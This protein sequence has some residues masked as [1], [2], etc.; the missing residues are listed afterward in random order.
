MWCVGAVGCAAGLE[1][2]ILRG[3]LEVASR[4]QA[5]LRQQLDRVGRGLEL[6]SGS[7]LGFWRKWLGYYRVRV[8][9]TGCQD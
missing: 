5:D 2:R 6:G 1:G 7:G 9:V 8:R 4:L 3:Q